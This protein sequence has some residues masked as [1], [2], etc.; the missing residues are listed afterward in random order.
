MLEKSLAVLIAAPVDD[1]LVLRRLLRDSSW[2]I[3]SATSATQALRA[4]SQRPWDAVIAD[5]EALIGLSGVKL[6]SSVEAL[7]PRTLRLLV[8]RREQRA[9][10]AS[11]ALAGRFQLFLRPYFAAPVVRALM[12]WQLG[13]AAPDPQAPEAEHDTTPYPLVAGALPAR[14]PVLVTLAELAEAALDAGSG[15]AARVSELAV[16]LGRAAGLPDPE[17][18]ALDEAA[19]LHDVGELGPAGNALR[20]RRRL[21]ADE[22]TE[23]RRH[24]EASALIAERCGLVEAARLAIKHH[25]ERWDGR[26]YPDG[27]RRSEIPLLARILAIAD[28]WDALSN[29]RPYHPSLQAADCARSLRV[30]GGA[31]LD[32]ALVD[33]FLSQCRT[34]SRTA[35]AARRS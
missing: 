4:V 12:A 14:R 35:A 5:E 1:A 8:A 27:L 10:L 21:T 34:R 16:A 19:L 3:E 15:H 31:Q 9:E 17:L 24:P 2:R 11:L 20:L 30:A 25:H 18:E 23:V 22:L 26:G 29:A 6:L 32:P 28:T 13:R 7:H 33:L